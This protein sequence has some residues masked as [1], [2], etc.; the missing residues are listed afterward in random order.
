MMASH[1]EVHSFIGETHHLTSTCSAAPERVHGA[2][3]INTGQ[4]EGTI[5]TGYNYAGH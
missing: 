2:D 3:V 5:L 1:E 4:L